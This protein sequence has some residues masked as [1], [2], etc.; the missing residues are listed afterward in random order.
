MNSRVAHEYLLGAR[1]HY[2]STFLC[3]ALAHVQIRESRKERTACWNGIFSLAQSGE[4]Q[5]RFF[6]FLLL[7]CTNRHIM[8]GNNYTLLIV[9]LLENLNFI[10]TKIK[11]FHK[12]S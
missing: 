1:G 10:D 6:F 5:I 9:S 11:L 12:A 3:S 4:V 2:E 7:N 8:R